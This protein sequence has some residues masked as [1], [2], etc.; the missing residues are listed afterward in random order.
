MKLIHILSV[1]HIV[2]IGISNEIGCRLQSQPLES[3]LAVVLYRVNRD[4]KTI[5][6]LLDRSPGVYQLHY[7]DLSWRECC[8]KFRIA[9][10]A[11]M[12]ALTA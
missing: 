12:S 10:T 6:N 4:I 8:V 1:K 3:I 7:V 2:L 5:S 9:D 11:L